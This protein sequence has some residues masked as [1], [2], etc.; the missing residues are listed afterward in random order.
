LKQ[1]IELIFSSSE[2]QNNPPVLV[3]IG[4]SGHVHEEWK[5]IAKHSICVAFDADDRE[6]SFISNVS[7]DFHKFYVIN[8]IV[9]PLEDEE[10]KFYLTKSPY[11]S[12]ILPPKSEKLDDWI[13]KPLFE[14]EK[15]VT[16]KTISLH[17]ALKQ[18]SLDRVDWI[19]IDSQG[20]DLS[21]FL[22]LAELANTVIV[23]EF[24]PG[25]IDAYEG[26]DK[27]YDLFREM[28]NHPF[29]LSSL[30]VQGTKRMNLESLSSLTAAELELMARKTKISPC[31]ANARYFNDFT[32]S[33]GKRAYLL[34]CAFAILQA[35]Y[36]FA[37]EII[38]KGQE[39]FPD[40]IF[41]KTK[42]LLLINLR[43]EDELPRKLAFKQRLANAA[44]SWLRKP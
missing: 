22:S 18:L 42:E 20:T 2:I 9:T 24:E 27:L 13:F 44:I 11:C 43:D 26:E 33:L 32:G 41:Q 10:R 39:L 5:E 14:V 23:A 16:L 8:R 30:D 6:M 34:G 1:I 3:D 17:K 25:I 15:I 35:Q 29:W 21:L 31:W 19:K 37:L 4:A 12:S 38:I 36:A 40:P 28:E 7:T